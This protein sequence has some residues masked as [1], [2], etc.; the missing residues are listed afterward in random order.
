M[1][2]CDLKA[3]TGTSSRVLTEQEG[4]FT[5]GVLV[6]SNFGKLEELRIDGAPVGRIL[7]RERG[8][9]DRRPG[10]AGSIIGVA[11][12]DA[13]LLPHQLNRLAKRMALG[14][15]R[16]GS[17]AAHGSGEIMLAFSTANKAPRHPRTRTH[18]YNVKVLDDVAMNPLYEAIIDATEEAILNSLLGAQEMVGQ[19]GRRARAIPVE[20]VRELLR[21]SRL[22]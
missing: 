4:G 5:V 6:Q 3:G 16:V 9:I 12:T 11:A 14:I 1:M 17:H 19:N 7:A 20:R 2:T 10:V 15:G 22:E 18:T 13:P 21:R 8:E